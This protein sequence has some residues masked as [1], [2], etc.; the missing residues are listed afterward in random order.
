MTAAPKKVAIIEVAMVMEV[1]AR[2]TY[3]DWGEVDVVREET[4]K[5]TGEARRG[6]G[7]STHRKIEEITSGRA[8]SQQGY[9]A[10]C[11]DS[12]HKATNWGYE[13]VVAGRMSPYER[14]RSS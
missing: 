8:N 5:S 1:P 2:R 10:T 7:P 4:S 3:L 11:K 9:A 6:T 14:R 13:R 12:W